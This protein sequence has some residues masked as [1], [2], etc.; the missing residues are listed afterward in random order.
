MLSYAKVQRKN[1]I[2]IAQLQILSKLKVQS[3]FPLL[4]RQTFSPGFLLHI[5]KEVN[6][7]IFPKP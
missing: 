4:K 5:K 6:F 7:R 2:G 3:G 1:F